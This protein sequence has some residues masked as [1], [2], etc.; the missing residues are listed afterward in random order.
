MVKVLGSHMMLKQSCNIVIER[1]VMF[2]FCSQ[3]SKVLHS[4]KNH[5][6]KQLFI[7]FPPLRW[8]LAILWLHHQIAKTRNLVLHPHY[9]RIHISI[10]LEF[11]IGTPNF[12]PHLKEFQHTN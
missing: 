8:V 7:C 9:Q 4:Q 12:E 6:G 2:I 3:N 1:V 10:P 11:K 5:I